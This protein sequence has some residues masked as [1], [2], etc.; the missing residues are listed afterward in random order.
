MNEGNVH[1]AGNNASVVNEDKHTYPV[2]EDL[3]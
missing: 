2:E 3:F 1:D